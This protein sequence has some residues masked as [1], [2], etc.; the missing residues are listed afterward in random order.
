MQYEVMII[1]GSYS[2]LSAALA[3]GRSLRN[4]LIIDSGQP[5]NQQT[6]HSHNFLTRD[7]EQPADIAAKAREQVQQ[8]TTVSFL[9]DKAETARQVPGGFEIVT[10]SGKSFSAKKLICATGIKDKLP[11]IEGVSECWGISVIH[12]PYCHGYE[13]RDQPTA[14]LA[15]GE[16]ALHLAGLVRNLSPDVSIVTNGKASFTTEQTTLL[17]RHNIDIIET[18]LSRIRHDNGQLSA[19]EFS[20]GHTRSFHSMYAALPFEPHSGIPF[21]L[22][23]ELTEHGH[24]KVDHLQKTSVTGVYVCGDNSSAMRSVAAAVASGN[25]AGAMVN[26]ELT[27]E[28]F[29]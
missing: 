9:T 7:G 26:K 27:D 20:D 10:E 14:I 3:L 22:G 15:N 2:G 28:H 24:I 29:V 13:N 23:C 5:C 4:V 11:D 8:Y 16:R 6:P 21:Q 19:L 12:C 17:M 18:P 25:L 1:G